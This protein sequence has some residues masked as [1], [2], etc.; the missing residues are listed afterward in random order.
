MQYTETVVFVCG[1]SVLW[2]TEL[3]Q[4]PGGTRIPLASDIS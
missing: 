2:H 1:C 3:E 4:V